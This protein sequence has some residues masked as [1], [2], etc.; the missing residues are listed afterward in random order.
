[1]TLFN[2]YHAGFSQGFNVGEAVNVVT[3]DSFN[4][5]KKALTKNSLLKN[6]KPPVIC[7]DWMVS[8]NLDNQNVNQ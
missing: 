4:V 5:I 6:S 7:Y 1:L 8:K 3:M 2:A